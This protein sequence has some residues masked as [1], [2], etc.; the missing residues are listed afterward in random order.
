MPLL[1]KNAILWGQLIVVRHHLACLPNRLPYKARI[2]QYWVGG[3][4]LPWL[5]HAQWHSQG[6]YR[7]TCSLMPSGIANNREPTRGK[8]Q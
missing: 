1:N 5:Y 3:D 2:K 6:F 8:R 4:P 7:S